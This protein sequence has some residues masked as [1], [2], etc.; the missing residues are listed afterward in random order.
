MK[1]LHKKLNIW[2]WDISDQIHYELVTF[3]IRYKAVK[4]VQVKLN[5]VYSFRLSE[6]IKVMAMYEVIKI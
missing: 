4:E 2:M 5:F 6:T 1:S 3:E